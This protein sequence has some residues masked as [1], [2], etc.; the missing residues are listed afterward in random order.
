[1]HS[2][3]MFRGHWPEVVCGHSM[4]GKVA[5]EYIQQVAAESGGARLPQH[6]WVLDSQPGAVPADMVP[7]VNRVLAAVKVQRL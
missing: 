3:R 1:M 5:L 6:V 2:D 7:D 4:G